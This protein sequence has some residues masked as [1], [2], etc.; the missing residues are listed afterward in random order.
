MEPY[1]QPNDFLQ[2]DES[3]EEGEVIS[4][5]LNKLDNMEDVIRIHTNVKFSNDQ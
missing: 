4:E 3:T 5:F 2:V 1:Y